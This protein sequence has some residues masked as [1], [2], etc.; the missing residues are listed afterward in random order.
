MIVGMQKRRLFS[1]REGDIVSK[2]DMYDKS[3]RFEFGN[4]LGTWDWHSF[5]EA[6]EQGTFGMR[7][8]RP[9]SSPLFKRGFDREGVIRYVEDLLKRGKISPH[10]IVISN[11]TSFTDDRR[12][13]QGEF[14]L[15]PG[16]G[17]ALVFCKI[18]GCD[19]CREEMRQPTSSM[20]TKRRTEAYAY[21]RTFMDDLSFDHAMEILRQYPDAVVEFTSF[22]V[23]VG[24]LGWNTIFWEV[25]N[26]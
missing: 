9:G 13:L 25:R 15:E 11:D 22:D 14:W 16:E 23:G 10:D 1:H 7:D 24:L 5:K 20:Q 4:V 6:S 8:K 17:I 19:T 18:G 21:M 12:T 3:R 26:Y 2:R